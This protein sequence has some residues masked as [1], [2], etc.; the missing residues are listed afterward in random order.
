[1]GNGILSL[2]AEIGMFP[3]ESDASWTTVYFSGKKVYVETKYIKKAPYKVTDISKLCVA[4]VVNDEIKMSW[5]AGKNN[6]EYSCSIATS[7]GK[8]LWSDKHYKKNSFL[9]KIKTKK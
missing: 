5:N 7:K 3:F 1:M 8:V 6:V 4:D 2:G 9:I